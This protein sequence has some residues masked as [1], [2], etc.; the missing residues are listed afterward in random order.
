[1]YL[2]VELLGHITLCL[3]FWGAARVSHSGCTYFLT[4]VYENC[5][6]STSLL[7][8]VCLFDYS[9][10]GEC[11]VVPR[12]V[13]FCTSLL[14]SDGEHLFMCLLATFMSFLGRCLFNSFVH[15]KVFLLFSFKSSFYVLWIQVLYTRKYQKKYFL[16]FYVLCF[17]FLDGVFRSTK[18]FN[19][20]EVKELILGAVYEHRFY[21]ASVEAGEKLLKEYHSD[22]GERCDGFISG[23]AAEMMKKGHVWGRLGNR[24]G[25]L[26]C[27][28]VVEVRQ[29][30]KSGIMLGFELKRFWFKF[31]SCICYLPQNCGNF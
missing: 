20:G 26:R 14:I 1:M 5:S 24:A 18:V 6:F 23:L 22:P 30:E 25:G 2:E 9:H 17:N 27:R 15:F 4:A 29:R 13:L 3:I 11:E 7:P 21:G 31:W 12:V 16:P 8:V 28:I 10:A 19:F